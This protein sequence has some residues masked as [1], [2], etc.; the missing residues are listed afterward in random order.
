MSGNIAKALENLNETSKL[1]KS[2]TR[3]AEN[4]EKFNKKAKAV[5]CHQ[6]VQGWKLKGMIFLIFVIVI[7]VVLAAAGVFDNPEGGGEDTPTVKEAP[8]PARRL[9]SWEVDW[10]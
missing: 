10:N 7:L 4:A 5:K 6:M 9:E 2:T 1:Q 3:L 8:T